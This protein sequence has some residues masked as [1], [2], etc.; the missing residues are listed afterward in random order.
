MKMSKKNKRVIQ[1][2][3]PLVIIIILLM[4]FKLPYTINVVGEIKPSREWMLSKGDGGQFL[5]NLLDN[6]KGI[7]QNYGVT[8]SE[9]GEDIN[10]I[11]HPLM[12]SKKTINAGDT[13]GI[14]YSSKL[15]RRLSQ[16]K[17]D[18]QVAETKLKSAKEKSKVRDIELLTSQIKALQDEKETLI[19]R[20]ESF[21]II[22]PF[23][24][25]I[26]Q[27]LLPGTLFSIYDT[28][29]YII[30]MSIPS[31]YMRYAE[32]AKQV[33][34]LSGS[35]RN[36]IDASM[37]FVNKERMHLNGREAGTAKA[38]IKGNPSGISPGMAVR[39]SIECERITIM[40]YLKRFFDRMLT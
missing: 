23:N 18:L 32:K 28:S 11:L 38:V 4:P 8:Q 13:I 17:G 24:G 27:F 2:T 20:K 19:G 15:E 26:S 31:E 16:L 7:T 34:Y 29:S 39:C 3:V 25:L 10:F 12:S 5:T 9:R 37:F 36:S 40:Q 21:T 33:K 35:Q 6:E 1:I 22:S 14:I 30:L